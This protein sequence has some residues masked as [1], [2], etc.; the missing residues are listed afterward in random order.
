MSVFLGFDRSDYPGDA[1]MKLLRTQA[2]LAFTGFYLAPA[3]S[4]SDVSWMG[5]RSF[6]SGLGF[7]FA[8]VYVGR[9]VSG[10]GAS[11]QSASQG[12]DD[13]ADAA[14]LAAQAGFPKSSVLYLDIES[15]PPAPQLLVGYYQAWVQGVIDSGFSP[16]VY[17]SH[18]L[19]S[20]FMSADD[21]AAVWVFQLK[22][23]APQTFSPPLP[24]PDPASSS[25]S[26]ARILQFAQ[27]GTLELGNQQVTPVDLDTAVVADPS[28]R[29]GPTTAPLS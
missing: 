28:V 7:G 5:K 1:V 4:H 3:P 2:K 14:Q 9:Q 18:L 20:Q 16:G 27:N 13:G 11:L 10:P 22:S 8:P 25:F 24:A 17:C 26:G 29:T 19:A 21:R 15:G 6:L 23:S 12:E